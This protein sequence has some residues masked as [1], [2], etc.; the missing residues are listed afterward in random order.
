MSKTYVIGIDFGTLSARGYLVSTEDGTLTAEASYAYP[1]GLFETEWQGKKLP[2]GAAI[3]EPD[4][5]PETLIHVVRELVGKGKA[6]GIEPENIVGLGMDVT[7]CT[8]LPLDEQGIPMAHREEFK[9]DPHAQIKMWKYHPEAD[10][11]DRVNEAALKFEP[12]RMKYLGGS[13]S[14]EWLMP[15][16][17]ETAVLAPDLYEKTRYFREAGDWMVEML[18]GDLTV[19]SGA[20][21]Q[22]KAFWRPGEGYPSQAFYEALDPS[23]GNAVSKLPSVMKNVGE[24]AGKLCPEWAEKLGLE[25]G[26]IIA[27]PSID[28]HAAGPG[29]GMTGPGELLYILGT[30]SCSIVCGPKDIPVKGIC[31]S[32]FGGILPDLYG[33]EAGQSSV[34]DTFD[35]FVKNCVPETYEN[36]AKEKGLSV[37]ELLTEKASHLAVGENHLVALDWWNG[38]RSTL[39]NADLTGL[40]VGFRLTTKPEEIYR[41]LIESTAYGAKKILE[42]YVAQGVKVDRVL[43]TGGISF[44]NSLMMQIYADVLNREITIYKAPN[45]SALTSAMMAA[46]AAGVHAS[47]QEAIKVMQ[48]RDVIVYQ[49]DPESADKYQKLYEQ[50]NELYEFFGRQ[51]PDLMN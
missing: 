16:L 10:F 14:A 18:T 34:G 46:A 5:Y 31:G 32:A 36:E 43:A 1:H 22:Y 9:K 20:Y 30:S 41:A 37:H 17:L 15:K 49:P 13:V 8:F 3:E 38:N 48:C 24:S 23:L 6:Q 29:S 4:D 7:A 40:L 51:H 35:W 42:N 21:A 47:M 27:A 12:D 39:D 44:K 11:T 28:A 19:G 45:A 50:Y 25:P 33:F 26:I 2:F